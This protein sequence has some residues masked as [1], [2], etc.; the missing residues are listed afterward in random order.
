MCVLLTHYICGY[1]YGKEEVELSYYAHIFGQV[2]QK[3]P[4]KM[5]ISTYQQQCAI[6]HTFRY[7]VYF[8]KRKLGVFKNGV[9]Q[10][11]THE[12]GLEPSTP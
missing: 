3:Y 5:V 6:S 11:R 12:R 2:R 4:Y 1:S 7:R 10:F 9:G 8:L